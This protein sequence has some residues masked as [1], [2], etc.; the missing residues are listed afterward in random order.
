MHLVQ[1]LL[2]LYDNDGVRIEPTAFA[3]VRDLLA[4]RFGGVTA[5]T[6]A[7]ATGLWKKE[8]GEIDRDEVVAVEVM[9]DTLERDWWRS[10]S[11][12]L[13]RA[14]RQQTVVVRAIAI[15]ALQFATDR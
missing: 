13:A 15:E 11:A 5:Y 6:R 1:L 4:R 3:S 9:V 14:F 8:T 12:E 7:P 2:P 10:Y